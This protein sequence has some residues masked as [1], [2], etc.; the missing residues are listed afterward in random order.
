MMGYLKLLSSVLLLGSLLTQS[1][2]ATQPL[3]QQGKKTLFQRVLS[4]PTCELVESAG[5]SGGKKAVV[6]SRYYVY[7]RESV[8]GKEWLQVGPDTF[9]KTVGWLAS[10]SHD[11]CQGRD[12]RVQPVAGRQQNGRHCESDRQSGQ[13]I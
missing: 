6:F 4:T 3:L 2:V 11:R 1:A 12:G 13:C 10:E 7:Q 5:G 9:G 8:N